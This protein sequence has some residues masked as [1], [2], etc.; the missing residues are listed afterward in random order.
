MAY[1]VLFV[2]KHFVRLASEHGDA[3]TNMKLQKL[4]YYA[5]GAFLGLTDEP[6]FD[7]GIF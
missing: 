4:L 5:Q 6:V 7:T 1:D 3:I 2:A